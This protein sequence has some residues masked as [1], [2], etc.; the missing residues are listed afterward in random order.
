LSAASRDLRLPRRTDL[1]AAPPTVTI[2][3]NTFTTI[4][5]CFQEEEEEEGGK[6]EGRKE[7][8]NT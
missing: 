2:S 6:E 5:L 4:C 8:D 7:G 1:K 3:T